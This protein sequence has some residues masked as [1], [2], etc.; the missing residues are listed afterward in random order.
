MFETTCPK[1]NIFTQVTFYK[2]NLKYSKTFFIPYEMVC[3][4]HLEY[5][6]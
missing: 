6:M 3:V 1:D 4:Y 5:D 2:M